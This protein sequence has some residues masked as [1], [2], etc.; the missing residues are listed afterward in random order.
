MIQSRRNNWAQITTYEASVEWLEYRST[1]G[2]GN[3]LEV[4]VIEQI[5]YTRKLRKHAVMLDCIKISFWRVGV[6]GIKSRKNRAETGEAL[7]S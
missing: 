1:G 6:L 5:G 7:K 2:P 3:R 4:R